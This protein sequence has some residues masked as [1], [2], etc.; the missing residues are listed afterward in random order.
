MA[1]RTRSSA[2]LEDT[3][4]TPAVEPETIEETSDDDET[5]GEDTE[6]MPDNDTDETKAYYCPG[7]GRQYSYMRECT[8]RPEAPHA[9]I[10][11]VSTDE[12]SG[13]EHTPAPVSA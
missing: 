10:E 6:D 2:V 8:G 11:L 5:E 13:D 3:E 7:C 9:P 4:S 12:L 1:P